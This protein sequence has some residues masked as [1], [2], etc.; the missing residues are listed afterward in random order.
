MNLVGLVVDFVGGV[1]PE[2]F[3]ELLGESQRG[4]EFGSGERLGDPWWRVGILWRCCIENREREFVGPRGFTLAVP[5]SAVHHFPHKQKK[6]VGI[7]GGECT[8]PRFVPGHISRDCPN[9][10]GGGGGGGRGGGGGG[11]R[12]GGSGKTIWGKYI[13]F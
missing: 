3:V 5:V 10:S 8:E 7:L 11:P 12:G 2:R 13:D 6:N 9:S 4:R 1:V